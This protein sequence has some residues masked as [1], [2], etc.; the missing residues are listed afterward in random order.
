MGCRDGEG[1]LTR[2]L[3]ETGGATRAVQEGGAGSCRWRG[4]DVK[5][6][7]LLLTAAFLLLLLRNERDGD[8]SG[9]LQREVEQGGEDILL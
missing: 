1:R 6:I 3:G 9:V 4:G 8:D 2:G 7:D 5:G